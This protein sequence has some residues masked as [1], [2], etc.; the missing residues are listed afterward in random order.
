M[1]A[2]ET[3]S[4]TAV[5]AAGKKLTQ[6]KTKQ[7]A[8]DGKVYFSYADVHATVQSLVP[9]LQAFQPTVIIA[10]GGGGFIPAR[11]LRTSLKVP[12]LAVSLELYDDATNTVRDK[13]KCLQWFDDTQWP[14]N[15]VPNGNVLIID[16]VDDTRTTLQYCVEQVRAQHHPARTGVAVVHNK[17]KPKRG[18]LSE[19]DVEYFAGADV[20]DYWNCY[21]WDSAAYNGRTIEDH[22]AL[23]RSCDVVVTVE[24]DDD[25]E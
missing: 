8:A 15:L 7:P 3:E 14:G 25:D 19:G 1:T 11:I 17:L 22:E 20:P 16:E 5:P 6:K 23:A 13:V 9:R 4:T 12:I 2:V 10:I 24:E 18:T 21:P